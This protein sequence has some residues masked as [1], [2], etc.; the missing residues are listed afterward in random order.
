MIEPR[1]LPPA[2][3]GPGVPAITPTDSMRPKN[4]VSTRIESWAGRVA[5]IYRVEVA[6]RLAPAEGRAACPRQDIRS[7]VV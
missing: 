3:N 7:D 1:S 4:T 5:G 2:N 6:L